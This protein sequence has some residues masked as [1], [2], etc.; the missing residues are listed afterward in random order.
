MDS[1]VLEC[2]AMTDDRWFLV[3][4]MAAYLGVKRVTI[5][6]EIDRKNIPAIK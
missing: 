2:Q 4:E 6:K 1:S 5:N 3:D